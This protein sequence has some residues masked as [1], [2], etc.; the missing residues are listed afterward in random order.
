LRR[1]LRDQSE[2]AL[3]D[4]ADVLDRA[5][6]LDG[7]LLDQQHDFQL[8]LEVGAAVLARQELAQ[9][10]D[11]AVQVRVHHLLQVLDDAEAFS[12]FLEYLTSFSLL[13]CTI[14]LMMLRQGS[15]WP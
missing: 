7:E 12:W 1:V 14:S 2:Q 8:Q 11:Q 4:V 6:T 10:G 9:R 15:I 3:D 13:H 5:G